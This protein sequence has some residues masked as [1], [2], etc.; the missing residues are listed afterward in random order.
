[1]AWT[2]SCTV[3]PGSPPPATSSNDSATTSFAPPKNTHAPPHD[4]RLA[5]K[6]TEVV[7]SLG[8]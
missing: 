6:L 4:A 7:D 8:S 2:S 5:L 1:M 3:T